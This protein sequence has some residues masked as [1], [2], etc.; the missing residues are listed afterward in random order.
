MN[1]LYERYRH[2]YDKMK[3]SQ[4]VAKMKIF[5]MM[6]TAAT[7]QIEENLAM[8]ARRGKRSAASGLRYAGDTGTDSLV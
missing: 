5:A 6:G 1:A 8:A 3:H 7:M 2:L 4:D